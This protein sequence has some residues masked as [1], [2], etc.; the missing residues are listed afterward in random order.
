MNE[1]YLCGSKIKQIHDVME[2]RANNSLRA[3]DL[4]MAQVGVLIELHQAPE[5]RLSLK[6]LESLLHVAQSTAAGIV[7]RL[8]QK[9][10]VESFGDLNDRRIK[11]VRMTPAGESYYQI[12]FQQMVKADEDL[13]S[14]LTEK[15]K[16]IFVRLLV[17]ICDNLQ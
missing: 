2:K 1:Q 14:V 17:K 9:G 10:F 7:V 8:E 4:T 16:E 13:L 3:Q 5:H 15:E 11:M 12:A 6:E